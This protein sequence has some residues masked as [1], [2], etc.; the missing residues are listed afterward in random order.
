[1]KWEKL[2]KIYDP[3]KDAVLFERKM[4]HGANPVP[5]L[6]HDDVFRIFFNSLIFSLNPFINTIRNILLNS[7][8]SHK[9]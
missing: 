2:G 1:M 5:M 3:E 6:L 8:I 7:N 9:F 4:S